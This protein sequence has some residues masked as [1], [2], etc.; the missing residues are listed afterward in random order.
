[1]G[2][3]RIFA[4][5]VGG[6]SIGK[7]KSNHGTHLS[8]L[9]ALFNCLNPFRTFT[10]PTYM[11]IQLQLAFICATKLLQDLEISSKGQIVFLKPKVQHFSNFEFKQM[12]KIREIGLVYARE[13]IASLKCIECFIGYKVC[14]NCS[15]NVSESFQIASDQN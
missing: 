4:V 8:G 12:D 2:C 13:H 14:P 15:I 10:I 11:D 5:G 9:V 7:Y 1:M 6:C 3:N